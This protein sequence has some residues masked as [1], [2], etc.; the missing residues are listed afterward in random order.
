[1]NRQE[2]SSIMRRLAEFWGDVLTSKESHEYTKLVSKNAW[3]LIEDLIR[4]WNIYP[5]E[6]LLENYRK[7]HDVLSLE[8]DRRSHQ[9]WT[10]GSL[11]VPVSFLILAQAVVGGVRLPWV[12]LLMF[13]SLACYVTWFLMYLRVHLFNAHSHPRIHLL[14]ILLDIR[15]YNFLRD[16]RATS[17]LMRLS[18][19]VFE[20][21]LLLL[22][23]S[24]R[25]FIPHG[26]A[27]DCVLD[28]IFLLVTILMLSSLFVRLFSSRQ[29]L[30]FTMIV[31]AVF[32][33]SLVILSLIMI[34]LP[35][36]FTVDC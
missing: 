10:L 29:N 33:A 24:W 26:V 32:L 17:K 2:V 1:M 22:I 23:L 30:E 25:I 14:E 28:I 20:P 6:E 36:L 13:A 7:E 5:R 15:A 4:K 18:W 21:A 35:R 3:D 9:M 19:E 12:M 8:I 34:F 27:L 16:D 11:F 31:L